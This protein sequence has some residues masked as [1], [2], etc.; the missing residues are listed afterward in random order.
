MKNIDI[1]FENTHDNTVFVNIKKG[2]KKIHIEIIPI[3]EE[4]YTSCMTGYIK[5]KP[6]I[7]GCGNIDNV[8]KESEEFVK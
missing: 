1:S 3:D 8:W 2:D 6:K 5:K 4:R 7:S